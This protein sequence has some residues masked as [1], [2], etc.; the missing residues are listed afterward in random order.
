MQ[1]LLVKFKILLLILISILSLGCESVNDSVSVNTGGDNDNG[2]NTP[3]PVFGFRVLN[4]FPHQT[5]A[6]TQGLVFNP[7]DNSLYEGTGLVGQSSLRQ[8]DLTTGQVLRNKNLPP[9]V[10]GEGLALRGNTLHQLTLDAGV[11]FLHDLTSF[12][13]TGQFNYP[14]QGWG[15]AN[16]PDFLIMSDGTDTLRFL[17]PNDFTQLGT[18]QVTD[19]G[20]FITG[21]NELELVDNVL[22]A[23]VFPT[24]VIA[25]IDLN[26][27]RVLFYADLT[28][29][30]DKDANGLEAN[31]VLNGIA[32]D[33]QARRF[34]V[35]GKRWPSVFQI[36][37]VPE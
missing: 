2:G 7:A 11:C 26:T 30:I 24:D 15:L 5:D 32:F 23:N 1:G 3:A 13:D 4:T 17:D 9:N 37:I 34:F 22:F 36:E 21:L 33:D 6:F 8:V 10:F 35:T 14:G 19:P 29:I 18:L 16:H 25:A 27:G 12:A 28:G 31:D 20:R